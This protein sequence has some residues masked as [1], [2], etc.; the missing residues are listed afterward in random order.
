V[1]EAAPWLLK[2]M[3]QPE[4]YYQKAGVMLSELVPAEGQQTDLLRFSSAR[5]K[6][7]RLMDILDNINSK[8]RRS[9][10]RLACEGVDR[11]CSMRH[12]F[13]SPNYTGDWDELPV[14]R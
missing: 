14:V 1:N 3:Y 2:K 5:N 8:Y 13:N 4:V 10:I 9:T 12:S 6:S 7:G 11:T